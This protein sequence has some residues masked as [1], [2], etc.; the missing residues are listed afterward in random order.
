MKICKM[1]YSDINFE[2]AA[3]QP[4]CNTHAIKVP[5]YEFHGDEV[6]MHGYA[7]YINQV[8]NDLQTD[9]NICK[10]CDKLVEINDDEIRNKKLIFSFGTVSL[11][12]H[13]F[14]CN[15]KCVYCNFW[16][17]LRK[18]YKI[19]P[20]LKSLYKQS[21][22][23]KNCFFSWGGGEP[24]IQPDFEEASAWIKTI[25]CSQYIHTNAIIYSKVIEQLLSS[26]SCSINVSLD[27]GT[28][29]IYE[30]VKGVKKHDKV[31]AN[32]CKY[33]EFSNPN[34]IHLK[35]IIFNDNNSISEIE[36]FLLFA[37]KTLQIKIINF[38]F[39]FREVCKKAVSQ[40]TIIAAA[41][42]I[43]R[44]VDLGLDVIP[45]F[46]DDDILQR[47]KAARI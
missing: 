21:L 9:S 36:N 13:R 7:N 25:G 37:A 3:I 24:T 23:R 44:A 4:C 32:L 28:R 31:I 14:L 20:P 46:V 12:M 22:L 8:L 42:L 17:N 18:S 6:D 33:R 43:K 38:S 26:Q 2:P 5:K 47:I 39:D 29:E 40:K 16:H 19:L 10:G 45:F 11:N 1:L 15:C 30:K 27:S 35:Y 34:A 41:F